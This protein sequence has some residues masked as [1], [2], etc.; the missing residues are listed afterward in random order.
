M[1]G[2]TDLTIFVPTT[3]DHVDFILRFFRDVWPD[4]LISYSNTPTPIS[5]KNVIFPISFIEEIVVYYNEDSYNSWEE[6]GLT[7]F[8]S[9]KAVYIII[10]DDAISFVFDSEQ[11]RS[12]QL[13]RELHQALKIN[14]ILWSAA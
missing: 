4:A 9:D 14:R 1:I 8:N 12:G 6:H 10:E 7:D 2:G 11:S 5:I 3:R 13:V